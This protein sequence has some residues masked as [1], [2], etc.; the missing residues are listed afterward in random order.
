M[1]HVMAG[2]ARVPRVGW[3]QLYASGSRGRKPV[4]DVNVMT[5]CTN[6]S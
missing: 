1:K 4:P 2:N 6:G 5:A 3:T